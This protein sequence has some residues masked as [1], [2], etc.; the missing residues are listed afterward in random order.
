LNNKTGFLV[1]ERDVN[2]L[3]NKMLRLAK[4]YNLRLKFS[5]AGRKHIEENYNQD[6]QISKIRKEMERLLKIQNEKAH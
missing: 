5:K 6:K 2:D 1:K 4:N 3:S